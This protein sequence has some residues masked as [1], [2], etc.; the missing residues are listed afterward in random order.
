LVTHILVWAN[1]LV[2][3]AVMAVDRRWVDPEVAA[4]VTDQ[5]K[6]DPHH[7]RWWTLITYAFF[8]ANLMHI[9]GNMVFL[10]VF[11]PN[12][13]D[14]FGRIGFLLFYLG[15]AASA[16]GLHV[17]LDH[18]PVIGASGAIAAVTGAYLVLF[19]RTHIKTLLFFFLIG[20]YSI[21]AWWFIGGQIAWDLF[22]QSTGRSG[23]VATLAHLGG[24]G[25]GAGISLLLLIT[26]LLKR[27]TMYDLFS[28]TRHAARRRQFQELTYRRQR[29]I[30]SGQDPDA[31]L[32]NKPGDQISP[33]IQEARGEVTQR[34]LADDLP[35][36]GVAYRRLLERHGVSPAVALLSRRSQYELANHLFKTGDHQ[37]AATAYRLFLEGYPGDPETPIVRLMLGLIN[38]R[39][40]NDPIK[41][42]EEIS[43]AMP[44]L[45]DGDHK[46]L[47][48]ELLA[49]L[50]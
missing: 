3:A 40:L 36:A 27:E 2:F 20:I 18:S 49:E 15:G 25:F 34:L 4:N 8:H 11:G 7:F 24:Y 14:R 37:T 31:L 29:A 26:G 39:Y 13:E 45:P 38:A 43:Q 19:P 46:T 35:G 16:G 1:V 23:N 10:W 28:L 5:F 30:A 48:R 12:V 6:L 17:L 33:A 47:A 32:K 21:P 42:K 44:G 50:G 41:A 22:N 9:L